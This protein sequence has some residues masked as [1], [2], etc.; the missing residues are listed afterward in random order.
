M[1]F[2]HRTKIL[3]P[4]LLSPPNIR[5]Q[6][7]PWENTSVDGLCSSRRPRDVSD[8]AVWSMKNVC[9]RKMISKMFWVS[10][11]SVY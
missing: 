10:L 9:A 11:I 7:T 1:M 4:P 3:A 5:V 2:P 8:N 6:E